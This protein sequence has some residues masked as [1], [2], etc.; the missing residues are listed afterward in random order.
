MSDFD[1]FDWDTWSLDDLYDNSVVDFAVNAFDTFVFDTGYGSANWTGQSGSIWQQ[2]WDYIDQTWGNEDSVQGGE[3]FPGLNP[4][5]DP[6]ALYPTPTGGPI[7]QSGGLLNR[8]GAI[9]SKKTNEY[10]DSGDWVEDAGKGLLS[11]AKGHYASKKREKELEELNREAEKRSRIAKHGF[12]THRK[13]F[14]R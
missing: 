3:L 4:N 10:I 14:A 6:N 13:G 11:M 7:Q 1:L 5:K 12:T 8:M 9:L 2:G